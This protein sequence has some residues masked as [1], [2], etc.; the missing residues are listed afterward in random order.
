MAFIFTDVAPISRGTVTL[1]SSSPSDPL[2]VDPNY[3]SHPTDQQ[4]MVA[5]FKRVREIAKHID[6]I[7][8]PEFA[9]GPSV[10]TDN[11]EQIMEFLR[12]GI[13]PF[14]HASATCKMGKVDEPRAV[15]DSQARV[16]GVEALRV[17]DTSAFPF[18]MPGHPQSVVYALA[19]KIA[20]DVLNGR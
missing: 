2:V 9:P 6:A 8:G 19:E 16:I 12:A 17:V 1:K 4:I 13:A 20:D 15:V 7:S 3:F 5:A 14:L 10:A 11:D 18:V